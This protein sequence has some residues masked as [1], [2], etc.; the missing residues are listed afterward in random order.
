LLYDAQ[1]LDVP[2]HSGLGYGKQD[3]TVGDLNF[4]EMSKQVISNLP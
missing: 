2:T 3:S 4:F 1:P